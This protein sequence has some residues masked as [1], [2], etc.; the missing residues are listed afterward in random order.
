[1][2]DMVHGGA[3]GMFLA[4]V[5]KVNYSTWIWQGERGTK[6]EES[7]HLRSGAGLTRAELALSRARRFT[8]KTVIMP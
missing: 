7:A 6:V 3:S 8:Q 2:L 1:M 4:A 5:K